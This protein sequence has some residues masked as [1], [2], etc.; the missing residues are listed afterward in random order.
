[1]HNGNNGITSCTATTITRATLQ[2]HIYDRTRHHAIDSQDATRS[3]I[4]S[5]TLGQDTVRLVSGAAMASH[6]HGG[7]L[8]HQEII[9]ACHWWRVSLTGT[10]AWMIAIIWNRASSWLWTLFDPYIVNVLENSGFLIQTEM[11]LYTFYLRGGELL[12]IH[13]QWDV[14][15][16]KTNRIGEP[17]FIH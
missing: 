4:G 6:G 17:W 11:F 5:H 13:S 15:T 14:T 7:K 12:C 1:M 2:T 3:P 9:M 8:F 16:Q 10:L